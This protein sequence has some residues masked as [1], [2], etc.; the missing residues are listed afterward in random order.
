MR[1]L[2]ASEYRRMPWKNGGG[3]TREIM[4][5][6]SGATLDSLDWRLSLATVASDG[7]FSVFQ[8]IDRTLCVIRGAGIR[9]H[10]GAAPP[11]TLLESS[12][13]CTFDGEATTRTTLI[14]GAIVDLNVMSRRGRWRHTVKRL[15]CEGSLHL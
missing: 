15:T 5:S 10:I 2:R 7:P 1:I 6:P 8:G 13:P 14:D 12:T 4:V 11:A 3:E 9:L